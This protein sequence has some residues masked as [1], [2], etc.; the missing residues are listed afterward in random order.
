MVQFYLLPSPPRA[1]P[2]TSSALRARGW[3][4]VRRGL[5]PGVGG[6]VKSK[7]TSCCS[8]EIRDFSVD[9]MAPDRVKNAYFHGNS[10]EFVGDWLVKNNLSKLKYVFE[11]TFILN[12]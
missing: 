4:I 2:G 3:G 11:G 7:I 5:V 6:R 1:T 9:T 10:L 12:C 8:C